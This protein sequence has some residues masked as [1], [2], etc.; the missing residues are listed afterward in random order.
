MVFLINPGSPAAPRVAASLS[1]MGFGQFCEPPR[2]DF[3]KAGEIPTS[4]LLIPL[5]SYALSINEAAPLCVA[6]LPGTVRRHYTCAACDT[7][8]RLLSAA[9]AAR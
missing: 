1:G 7:P 9:I 8:W 4:V 2:V 5:S 6:I 3:R